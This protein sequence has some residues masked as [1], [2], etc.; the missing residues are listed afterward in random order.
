M[1][2][3][4]MRE[5]SIPAAPNATPQQFF[6]DAWLLPAPHEQNQ[7]SIQRWE[8]GQKQVIRATRGSAISS[9]VFVLGQVASCCAV[10][11]VSKVKITVFIS[12][13]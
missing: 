2:A 7:Y 12:R 1:H 10:V 13:G 5:I 8:A 3:C 4:M 11:A 9:I 6:K